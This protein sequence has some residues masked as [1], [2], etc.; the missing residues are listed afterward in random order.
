MNNPD[1]ETRSLSLH[2]ARIVLP[3]GIIEG[4]G[5]L[6]EDG[7]ITRLTEST[8]SQPPAEV[9]MNLDGLTLFPGFIDAHI[10]GA[11]GIDTM[12]ADASDLHRVA[13]FLAQ[14]GVTGWLPTLVPAPAEDYRRAALAIGQLMREQQIRPPA[15]RSLGLHYEGPFINSAQC[16]ALRPRFFRSF[17]TPNDLSDLAKIDEDSAVH[18]MTLA[19]EVEGGIELVHELRRQGWVVSIGHTR[20]APDA[21]EEAQAAGARHMTHFMNA[22]SPLHHRAPG[23]VAW[24]LLND[25][26]TCDFI[27]DGIHLEPLILRLLVRCKT[28]ARLSL[29][30]D[31]VAPAGLGDGEYEIWGETISVSSGRTR[32]AQGNIAGSVITM[33]DAVR[34]M[35]GLGVGPMDVARM[36]SGNPARLLGLDAQLGAI[37]EG[38]QADLTA[39]DSEGRIRL[40]LVGGRVA[41]D[42]LSL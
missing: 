15:A 3:S 32:N 31:A 26:V 2:N 16:G 6:I 1:T 36:A 27:A 20:A 13:L 9:A 10:H 4:G 19:P 35:L 39:L 12:E 7:L 8:D 40:T 5:L 42:R 29:I 17:T 30:S 11:V 41:F 23:P 33:H 24:G 22:M 34:M 37:E 18:L 38:K 14:H 28:P 21:L 25:E